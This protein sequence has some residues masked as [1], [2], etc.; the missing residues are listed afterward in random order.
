MC[1]SVLLKLGFSFVE[2]ILHIYHN[3]AAVFCYN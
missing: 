2:F 3:D 1:L